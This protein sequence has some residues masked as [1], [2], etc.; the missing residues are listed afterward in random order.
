MRMGNKYPTEPLKIW[1]KAKEL[2]LSCYKNYAE[3]HD[4]G[5]LRYTG[6]AWTFQS[7][8]KGLSV[9][10]YPLTGEPYGASC[11]FMTS[12]SIRVLDKADSY[13]FPK[14]VCA[15]FRNYIGS[16]LLGEYVFGGSMPKP[17]FIW[18]SNI[19]PIHAKWFQSVSELGGGIPV[20]V[21]DMEAGPSPPFGDLSDHRIEYIAGQ[22]LDGIEWLEKVTGKTFDDEKF[23][24]AV[25][26]E[27]NSMYKWA[28]VCELNQ[29]IPAPL[30]EKTMFSLYVLNTLD[31]ASK[32]VSDFY[33]ELYDEVKDRV[34]RGIADVENEQCR[35]MTDSQPP[36]SFLELWRYY[37]R[38]YGVVS[39]GSLYTFSLEGAWDIKEDRLVPKKPLDLGNNRE[40]AC[41]ALA[42]W[43]ICRPIYQSHY[44]ADFKSK[45]MLMIARQW[46]VQGVMLHFNRGCQ[47]TVLG[48]VENLRALKDAGIPFIVLE[49]NMADER[50]VDKAGGYRRIRI[51]MEEVL[52]VKRLT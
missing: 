37:E 39:V 19:C 46:K 43:E 40:S 41:R 50:D 17:D 1:N 33:D 7:V 13:G 38:N 44:H 4:K 26:Y 14:S 29:N 36:W 28:K 10:V 21:V 3:A 11:G 30:G 2:R 5:A 48:A 15:Y 27:M 23:S 20:Y 25:R 35:V 42:E 8:P 34:K 6:G 32:E 22:L 16:F 52:G 24:Q 45:L 31:R 49:G 51:F 47:G 12:F 9:E 18:Q